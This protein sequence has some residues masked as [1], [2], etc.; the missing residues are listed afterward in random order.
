MMA[1][2]P[3]T[4]LLFGLGMAAAVPPSP[5]CGTGKMLRA[6]ECF[7]AQCIGTFVRTVEV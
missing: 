4:P 3:R 1:R 6:R 5:A 2:T 7:G